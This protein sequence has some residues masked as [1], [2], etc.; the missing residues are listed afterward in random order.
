MIR[1]GV[2]SGVF[3][4]NQTMSQSRLNLVVLRVADLERSVVFYQ[5]L[6][7][8]FTKHA[9]G[10]GPLH[11]ACEEDG[12]VF[13][14]YPASAQQPI[15]ASA[16]VGFIVVNIGSVITVLSSMNVNIVT[17]PADSPWGRRAVVADPDGHRVELLEKVLHG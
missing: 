2:Y 4:P 3:T 9:H 15:S 5:A 1:W 14:L 16:R 7:L 8:N 10:A 6:G 13:E 17:P 12:L 11:Y